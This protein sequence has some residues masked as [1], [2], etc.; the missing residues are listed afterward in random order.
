MLI[1]RRANSQESAPSMFA[2]CLFLYHFFSEP[3]TSSPPPV[4]RFQVHTAIEI[5]A[6]PAVVWKRLIAFPPLPAGEAN[7]R[8]SGHLLSHRKRALHR[9]SRA[10][11][12]DRELTPL[13][14]WQ[15]Q[16]AD[17]C[18][19]TRQALRFLCLRRTNAM[20]ETS[21][22]ENIHVRHLEITISNRNVLTS[23]RVRL[24]NGGTRLEGITTYQN[25][26]WP[27][28]ILAALDRCHHPQHP[29]SRF[30]HIKELAESDAHRN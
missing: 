5:A 1:H 11:Q 7:G 8:S 6:P 9:Q 16:G 10:S 24:P 28:P 12:P 14:H 19:G 15:F 4:P 29:Q 26:M 17:S 23:V 2:V 27:G 30:H 13:L 25:K 21:P 22:Y 18:L 20:K 3:S